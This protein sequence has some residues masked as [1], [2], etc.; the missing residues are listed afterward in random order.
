MI[1]QA[2]FIL[3]AKIEQF[4]HVIPTLCEHTQMPADED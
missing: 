3:A 2:M 4:H 1:N